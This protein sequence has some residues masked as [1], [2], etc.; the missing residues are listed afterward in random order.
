MYIIKSKR[1][2]L[3]NKKLIE[4]KGYATLRINKSK[5]IVIKLLIRNI[6]L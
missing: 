1:N 6:K 4:F 3:S 2:G 5:F